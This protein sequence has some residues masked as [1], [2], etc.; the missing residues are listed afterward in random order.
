MNVKD[1][2]FG[3]LRQT[4]NNIVGMLASTGR[5]EDAD[6]LAVLIQIIGYR[7]GNHFT[8]F[9]EAADNYLDNVRRMENYL[10]YGQASL[11]QPSPSVSVES[12]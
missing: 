9:D 3:E 10:K 4:V 12:D 11:S 8:D 7:S 2:D 6:A 5:R 1:I